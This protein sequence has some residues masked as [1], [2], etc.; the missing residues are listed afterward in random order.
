MKLST[1]VTTTVLAACASA[2]P[3]TT[4]ANKSACPSAGSYNSQKQYGCNPAHTYPQGQTCTLVN[5]CYILS[6]K[7]SCPAAGTTTSS[8]QYGCNPANTYPKGQTCTL[9]NG[10]Y[11]LVSSNSKQ[12]CPAAGTTTSSGQY[13][14]NPAHTYPEGQACTLQN[15]CYYL[16]NTSTI[17]STSAT[18]AIK[19]FTERK[20]D[21]ANISTIFFNISATNGGT[22]DFECSPYN[23]KTHKAVPSDSFVVGKTYDCGAN[24]AFSFAFTPSTTTS[25]SKSGKG[26]KLVVSQTD[27][28]KRSTGQ[29]SFG[30]PICRAGGSGVNDLVCSVP[31]QVKVRVTLNTA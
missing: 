4:T 6:S 14:C 20:L 2:A 1:V 9:Q 31:D 21:G 27:G 13:S 28:S 19:G 5:G 22:L 29:V 8:G 23:Q 15:G 3:A 7:Q 24:T 11:Y 25:D 26:N 18:Y 12:S 30:D 10:C 16:T 17:T